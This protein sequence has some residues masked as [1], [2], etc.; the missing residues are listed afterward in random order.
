MLDRNFRRKTGLACPG[1]S[2]IQLSPSHSSLL[3]AVGDLNRGRFSGRHWYDKWCPKEHT[4]YVSKIVL[5]LNV[6]L[7][8]KVVIPWSGTARNFVCLLFGGCRLEGDHYFCNSHLQHLQSWKPQGNNELVLYHQM[9][10]PWDTNKTAYKSNVVN[11]LHFELT[12]QMRLERSR[13]SVAW[14]IIPPPRLGC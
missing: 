9:L 12:W 4:N 11:I 3:L 5:F 8:F 7:G 10:H 13:L 14:S 1:H 6:V 2:N